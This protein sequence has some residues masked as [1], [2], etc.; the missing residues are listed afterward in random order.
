MVG[1][2][3]LQTH[4]QARIEESRSVD[5]DVSLKRLPRIAGKDQVFGVFRVPRDDLADE[6]FA[7][8]PLH[9]EID[10][11]STFPGIV[12]R[13]QLPRRINALDTD[14]VS[15]LAQAQAGRIPWHRKQTATFD[16]LAI[17]IVG[18]HR[19]RDRPTSDRR[20]A[21]DLGCEVVNARKAEHN[22]SGVDH[23]DTEIDGVERNPPEGGH[24]HVDAQQTDQ[25]VERPP[26]KPLKLGHFEST[27]LAELGIFPSLRMEEVG[28]N[29]VDDP[30]RADAH[31]EEEQDQE[32][33]AKADV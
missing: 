15:L 10:T 21:F 12:A 30:R 31:K 14:L 20:V 3:K 26:V 33:D 22:D 28:V 17:G 1:R 2:R 9:H 29:R 5:L 8:T 24:R 7:I 4:Q 25:K 32:R 11:K 18:H 27:P 6:T 23:P 19:D 16:D 13:E